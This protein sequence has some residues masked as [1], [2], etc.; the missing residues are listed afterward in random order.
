M[1]V[2]ILTAAFGDGHNTAAANVSQ[3]LNEMTHGQA[4]SP[5]YDPI[6]LA[7]PVMA[8]LLQHGYQIAI[9]SLPKIWRFL[10]SKSET[11]DLAHPPVELFNGILDWLE[12]EMKRFR[13]GAIVS[14][15]PL[16]ASLIRRLDP[17]IPVYTI[18]TDS[19]TVHRSWVTT[20]ST[21]HF[22]T[23]E[24]SKAV[25]VSLGLAAES[26]RVTGF[27]V[28]PDFARQKTGARTQL[29]R[30]LWICSTGTT[31]TV[32][33]LRSLLDNLAEEISISIVLGRQEAR[34]SGPIERELCR[35]T[36]RRDVAVLGWCTNIP[37]LMAT[38]DFILTK[39]GGATTHECLASGIPMGI[40]YIVP[41]QEEGNAELALNSGC[42]IHIS[43]AS[44]TGT[45][46]QNL[47]AS[48][49]YT[50]LAG[51]IAATGISD[52]AFRIARE[53]IA[54]QANA[55]SS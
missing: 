44:D 1:R 55:A 36:D 9:T 39:A 38:H 13:P 15:Y 53:I 32:T 20:P 37:H 30:L 16:Y 41:G 42:A 29:K 3:A 35:H 40:N 51:S 10:Y 33:T 7:N 12:T 18:I 49:K 28:A 24:K 21:L 43:K 11:V 48:G 54:A 19:I 4:D 17:G 47:V 26:V 46:I 22:V 45:V 27:P 5:V 31:S 14:T 2:L 6:S 23:D 34:L 52:G 50:E 25:A 8:G